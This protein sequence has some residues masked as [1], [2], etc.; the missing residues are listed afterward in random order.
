MKNVPTINNS[1]PRT[2]SIESSTII[3]AITGA[4]ILL[5]AENNF[6]S[7]CTAFLSTGSNFSPTAIC[8]LSNAD[9]QANM[10]PC[11]LSFIFLAIS[12]AEPPQSLSWS[13]KSLALPLP[14]FNNKFNPLIE[15]DVNVDCKAAALSAFPI[16]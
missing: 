8:I 9:W 16:P 15:S 14:A 5:M 4:G 3:T 6:V 12:S 7:V 2:A 13:L 1:G 10:S 11:K